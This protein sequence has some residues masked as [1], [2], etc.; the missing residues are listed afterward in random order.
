MYLNEI[1]HDGKYPFS[2]KQFESQDT[3]SLDG[4]L[5]AWLYECFRYFEDKA[6]RVV[7]FSY[8]T[9]DIDGETLT[10]MECIHRMAGDCKVILENY[11]D[12]TTDNEKFGLMDNA[13]KDLFKVLS[14][15]F[16]AMWW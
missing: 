8:Y 9:F 1:F 3:Y 6:S 15:V 13:M 7:D 5:I 11:E 12:F 2:V 10:Q 14:K 4:S 16:W